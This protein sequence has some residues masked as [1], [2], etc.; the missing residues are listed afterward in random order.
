[1]EN[2]LVNN[3][4]FYQEIL[5]LHELHK[6]SVD[7]YSKMMIAHEIATVNKTLKGIESSLDLIA[8]ILRKR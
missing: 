2:S 4:P 6:P 5:K 7:D 8:N 3:N 1:M